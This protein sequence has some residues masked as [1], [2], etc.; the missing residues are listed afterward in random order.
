MSVSL[1]VTDNF[2]GS[3]ATA[4]ITGTSG[5]VNT[6][7]YAR[8]GANT[9]FTWQLGGIRTGDGSIVLSIPFGVYIAYLLSGSANVSTV[10]YFTVTATA[11]ASIQTRCRNAVQATLALLP[12]PPA[13]NIY[14]QKWPQDSNVKFPAALVTIDG[15]QE[16]EEST[17]STLD[18]VG[19]P[20]KIMFVD[21]QSK[22]DSRDLQNYE[23]WRLYAANAFRNQRLLGIPE[24]KIC[25][26]EEY[27]IVDPNAREFQYMVSGLTVRCVCRQGRG[28]GYLTP[29]LPINTVP[30]FIT[31]GSGGS[32]EN[33]GVLNSVLFMG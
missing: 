1:T 28:I 13:A 4:T 6:V 11:Y 22:N 7:Y 25:R 8:M 9:Q 27:V 24:S 10:V 23:L 29:G 2:D 12:I 18:D 31:I 5:A 26:I 30:P 19:Y 21:R 33:T 16:T 17:L 15:V 14:Q 32:G 3:G 20:V